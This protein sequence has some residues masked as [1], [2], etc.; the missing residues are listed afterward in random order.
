MFGVDG[1]VDQCVSAV[2]S[3]QRTVEHSSRLTLT[4]LSVQNKL[5]VCMR[6][7]SPDSEI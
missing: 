1:L 5:L 6:V 7:K 4:L 3:E 2:Y